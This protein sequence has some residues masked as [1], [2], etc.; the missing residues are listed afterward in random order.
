MNELEIYLTGMGISY[1]TE[2]RFHNT[3][4]WR[5]DYYISDY[6]LAIE[7]E[8]GVYINGRHTRPSGFM[9]DIEKYNQLTVYGIILLR[10]TPRMIKKCEFTKDLDDI[11]GVL[12]EL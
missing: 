1:E 10:Y 5:T 2:Y 12:N 9:R 7:I 4:K 3:R 8:G 11:I 6:N